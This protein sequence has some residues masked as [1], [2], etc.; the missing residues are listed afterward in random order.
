MRLLLTS[1]GLS[2]N[3]LVEALRDL[4]GKPFAEAN[5][6]VLPTATV[7]EPGDHGWMLDDLARLRA[8]GWNE[9]SLLALNGLPD[10][11]V[12]GRLARA[13]VVYATGGN[14]YHLA[15]SLSPE[16]FDLVAEKVWVGASA[17]SMIFSRALNAHSAAVMGD[18]A[19]LHALGEQDVTSP[20][21]RFDWYLK[22]H[23]HSPDFP[24]RDDA[25]AKNLEATAGFPL[26]LLDDDSAVRVRG[27]EVD[28]VSEGVWQHHR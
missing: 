6:V 16:L 1:C 3:T 9:L 18:L 8:L 12:A 27:D 11:V 14:H 10:A 17:G 2:N 15:R 26:Y 5:V 21:A 25:W 7:A 19:D 20:F 28:V 22:P 4:L 13:D 24:D 23:L